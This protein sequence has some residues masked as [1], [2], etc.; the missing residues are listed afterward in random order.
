MNGDRKQKVT[1]A[2]C[3]LRSISKHVLAD[4]DFSRQKK[5]CEEKCCCLWSIEA[6][7][8][9]LKAVA[10]EKETGSQQSALQKMVLC[11]RKVKK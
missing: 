4:V 1:R 6:L 9:E 5:T 10:P 8:S 2:T 3:S 11:L 7:I